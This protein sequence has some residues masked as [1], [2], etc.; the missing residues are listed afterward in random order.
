MANQIKLMVGTS[1]LAALLTACGGGGSSSTQ[2]LEPSASARALP[3]EIAAIIDQE[4]PLTEALCPLTSAAPD[5]LG[6]INSEACMDEAEEDAE[7]DT[8][9]ELSLNPVVQQFCPQAAEVFDATLTFNGELLDQDFIYDTDSSFDG[10]A[11]FP[12][13]C[14]QEAAGNFGEFGDMIGGANPLTDAICPEESADGEVDPA[15]CFAEAA[16]SGGLPGGD[17]GG[18]PGADQITEQLCPETGAGEFNEE[19]PVNCLNEA[20]RNYVAIYDML[21][22]SNQLTQQICPEDAADGRIDPPACFAEALM[23]QGGFPGD[24]GGDGGDGGDGGAGGDASNPFA[25]LLEQFCPE[26]ADAPLGPTSGFDCLAE[27]GGN[28]QDVQDLI[29]GPN[30]LTEAVCPEAAQNSPIDPAACF[31]EAAEAFPGGELPG[32]DMENPFA[33]A[34]EAFCPET[35]AGEVGPTTPIDCLTEAGGNFQDVQDLLLGS[36]PLT[37]ALCPVASEE[38]PVDPAACFEEAAAGF[39]DGGLPGGE[40]NPFAPVMEQF[41]PDAAMADLGPTTPIDCLTEAGAAFGDVEELIGGANPLTEALCPEA[42]QNTP[43]DPAACFMEAT[44]GGGDMENPFAP[45]LEQFC[46]ETAAGDVG[47]TTPIDCLTEAGGNFQDVQDLLLGSNPLTKALCPVASEESP[48]DPAACFEE[49]A[50]GFGDGGLPGGEGNPFAP[51]MEQFCPDAAMADLGPTT[52][53]DCLT[54]AGAAFGDVEELIGGANPLTEALCPEASQNTPIDPAACFM[55]ATAGGGDME[56]PFAPALE[57]FCPETA[58]G[59]VGPTTPIDCLTEAGGNF[60]DVQDLLLGSNPL[61]E[62]L[63]PVASEESPVDPAAC[64]EEAA[65]DFGDGGLPGGEGNPFA[66]VMEQFCPEAAMADLGPT[67]PIDCL[68]EA[69]AAFG[70]VQ[71]LISGSNPLTEQLCPVESADGSV[72]PAACFQEAIAMGGELPGGGNPFAPVLEQFCPEAAAGELGP[73]TPIDCL[74]EAGSAF[75]DVQDLISGSNPL[76]EQLC[77]VESADGSVD[78]AACFQEA[79]AMGGELPGGD[80]PFGPALEQFCPNTADA[81]I[82]PTTPIDC[83]A[84]AGSTFGN[85]ED[86]LGGSNPLTEALCPM[87]SA[88]GTVDPAACFEDAVA[89]G[90]MGGDNPFAPALEQFCPETAALPLGPTTPADC[91]AEAGAGLAA[92]E[93]LLG[94]LTEPNPLTDQVCPETSASGMVDPTVCFIETLDRIEL[95]NTEAIGLLPGCPLLSAFNEEG[96]LSLTLGLGCLLNQEEGEA[97]SLEDNPLT[98]LFDS[99][100]GAFM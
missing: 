62:A 32:G 100:F 89:G 97:P 84:E 9:Y 25:P 88:E 81:E 19:T 30:P 73:T 14:L 79:I 69:G 99:L 11:T 46:P 67:T 22:E 58:A 26:T 78:P 45:A 72:D 86:I 7:E 92:L 80:N 50:A 51:V 57:Q 82:G 56:N 98:D 43:I 47:P 36:N 10:S 21:T 83:L 8:G 63:C 85:I 54:E 41:C 16:Q 61:T 53:I 66:P 93:E 70:D 96:N 74:T 90:G 5:E 76:T 35:A 18:L 65:A 15:N 91:L 6:N 87:A 59:D 60:Q 4:N 37:E 94:P 24:G 3:P 12:A 75:G 1:A 20:S 68:T 31:M 42:S 34:L 40:G 52:P 44:A 27:A 49:A 23:G 48:V 95:L 38:S 39:G 64:F 33:P 55:E 71:D 29:T 13:A 77:P 28:F 2:A 17:G